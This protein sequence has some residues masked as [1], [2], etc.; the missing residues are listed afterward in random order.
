VSICYYGWDKDGWVE[1][2]YYRLNEDKGV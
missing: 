2:C 1:Y